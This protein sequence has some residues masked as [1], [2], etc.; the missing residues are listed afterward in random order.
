[1]VRQAGSEKAEAWLPGG[2]LQATAAN[3]SASNQ[4]CGLF[5][6]RA[7][8][9]AGQSSGQINI[10]LGAGKWDGPGGVQAYA[11]PCAR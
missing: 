4:D 7:G 9:D 5:C 6:S 2:A 10:S 3:D 8:V 1:L 11:A